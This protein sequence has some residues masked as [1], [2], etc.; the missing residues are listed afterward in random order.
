MNTMILRR[1]SWLT[2]L[3]DWL[4]GPSVAARERSK[5]VVRIAG[6]R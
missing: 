3:L 2:L 5:P 6:L 1:A 4:R